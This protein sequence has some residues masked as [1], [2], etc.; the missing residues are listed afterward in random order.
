MTFAEAFS[1]QSHTPPKIL[2]VTPTKDLV[3]QTQGGTKGDKG[4]AGFAPDM[5]VGTFYSDTPSGMRGLDA[6]VTITTYAS[7]A[8]LASAPKHYGRPRR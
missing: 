3:R 2:V 5:T 7:L 1:Y 6:Q 4:F 8:K